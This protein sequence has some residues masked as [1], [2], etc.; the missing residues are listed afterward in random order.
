[1]R[2]SPSKQLSLSYKIDV[3]DITVLHKLVK[4]FHTCCIF[5]PA[6]GCCAL[7]TLVKIVIFSLA[8]VFVLHII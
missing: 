6:F 3:K 7:Q 8:K 4:V 5:G 1:M 2:L